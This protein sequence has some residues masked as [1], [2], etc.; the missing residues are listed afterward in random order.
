M[1]LVE[2]VVGS[3]I[4]IALFITGGF[5]I[6]QST[7]EQGMTEFEFRQQEMQY[8]MYSS[9]ID[10]TLS[11]THNV[12]NIPLREL[13]GTAISK[14]QTTF[15]VRD[16]VFDV[17]HEFEKILDE[18][19]GSG[20]Y[21]F[22]LAPRIPEL[23]VAFVI[24]GTRSF[25]Q[26]RNSLAEKLV[27]L[28]NDLEAAIRIEGDEEINIQVYI[29]G[30]F[31]GVSGCDVFPT[32]D[33]RIDCTILDESDLYLDE[34][35][36]QTDYKYVYQLH[37]PSSEKL[38]LDFRES[39]SNIYV[40]SDWA[41]GLAYAS[42]QFRDSSG[43][44]I[45]IPVSD[46]LAGS[47]FEHSCLRMGDSSSQRNVCDLC[48]PAC[49]EGGLF[50]PEIVRSQYLIDRAQFVIMENDH[51]VIPIL[52][53]ECDY[54]LPATHGGDGELYYL[55]NRDF[56]EVFGN[57]TQN[58]CAE[59]ECPGCKLKE[60]EDQ[61]PTALIC[62]QPE[63]EKFVLDQMESLSQQTS[64]TTVQLRNVNELV[65]EAQESVLSVISE[66]FYSAGEQQSDVPTSVIERTIPLSDGRLATFTLEIYSASKIKDLELEDIDEQQVLARLGRI[67]W[68]NK[69]IY[70]QNPYGVEFENFPIELGLIEILLTPFDFENEA[71]KIYDDQMNNLT[72]FT[73]HWKDAPSARTVFVKVNT[74]PVEGVNLTIV[75]T[76]K[77]M[78]INESAKYF[79]QGTNQTP[80]FLTHP[81]IEQNGTV[82][83]ANSTLDQNVGI[84]LLPALPFE[85]L[86]IRAQT[87]FGTDPENG[88]SLNIGVFQQINASQEHLGQVDPTAFFQHAIVG[89]EDIIGKTE[90]DSQTNKITMRTRGGDVWGNRD[91]FRYL[92]TELEGNFEII[93]ESF[94]FFEGTLDARKMGLMVRENL[95]QNSRNMFHV[96]RGNGFIFTQVRHSPGASTSEHNLSQFHDSVYLKIER[97]ANTLRS[98]Y[99]R[100]L[101]DWK[102][103]RNYTYSSLNENLL[104][105]LAIASQHDSQPVAGRFANITV[106]QDGSPLVIPVQPS[107][108]GLTFSFQE[109]NLSGQNSRI[110][111][112][113]DFQTIDTFSRGVISNNN[114]QTFEA[115]M[116]GITPEL[117]SYSVNY[118]DRP[119]REGEFQYL[120]S[121]PTYINF[122][123][124]TQSS[125][126]N[127]HQ[128]ANITVV[129]SLFIKPPWQVLDVGAV[130]I[131]E[132]ETPVELED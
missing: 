80:Y 84:T 113:P 3:V 22:T 125:S 34:N 91:N 52:T 31:P 98:Y 11:L 40:S 87:K 46:K 82:T 35:T 126:V 33:V 7:I 36:A 88:D 68:Q 72:L 45:L 51:T 59:D 71:I 86:T 122:Y 108:G 26:R 74:F 89:S 56:K 20:R 13:L 129:G 42:N 44:T 24:E 117:S 70:V 55:F 2:H 49:G 15:A 115:T 103:L 118:R 65:S 19:V 12:T 16:Q 32:T 101:S 67:D 41:S 94:G 78:K 81:Q 85:E 69:T 63:C 90:Y 47:S 4:L 120:R 97:Q 54:Q 104:V 111:T 17:G 105:G 28:A 124:L 107:F 48:Q 112:Y 43:I 130:I 39:R 27:D 123:S 37:S 58:L 6:Y 5:I 76:N 1:A 110:V 9:A 102:S 93:V 132:E 21:Y 10:A 25:E 61:S 50:T 131:E 23:Q 79:F 73:S 83:L 116:R 66:V 64:G 114:W 57:V 127:T 38:G 119:R 128:I 8:D 14:Q 92:Y 60:D 100:D 53:Y 77:T 121:S 96:H 75:K 30:E 99:S 18:L 95:N 106:I 109:S 29:L 62:R